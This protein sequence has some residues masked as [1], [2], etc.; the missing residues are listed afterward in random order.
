MLYVLDPRGLNQIEI[1]L[2]DICYKP[3]VTKQSQTL[4]LRLVDNFIK[5]IKSADI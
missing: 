4:H 5:I 1:P 2:K 3:I